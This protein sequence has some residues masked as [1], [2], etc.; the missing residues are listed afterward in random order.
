M[1]CRHVQALNQ[2]TGV[3]GNLHMTRSLIS[4]ISTKSVQILQT[5]CN[6]MANFMYKHSVDVNYKYYKKL[7]LCDFLF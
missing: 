3:L 4:Y 6:C 2:M 5:Y 1:L 7:L